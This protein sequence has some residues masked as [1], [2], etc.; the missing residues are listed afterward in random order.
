MRFA[1]NDLADDAAERCGV[2]TGDMIHPLPEGTTLLGLIDAGR[3][4]LLAAGQ[5]AVDR[6]ARDPVP[7]SG[8]RLIPPL[9]PRSIRDFVAF[10]AH[11][12]GVIRA[13]GRTAA[14]RS[15]G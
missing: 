8:V 6:P 11:I 3:A 13:A 1:A 15:R 7:V 4:A 10:E 2:V 9:R 5:A 12:E 14:A